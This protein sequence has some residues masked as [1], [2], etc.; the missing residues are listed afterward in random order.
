MRVLILE[1][2]VA[3]AEL[4]CGYLTELGHAPIVARTPA[5]AL[6]ALAT[7]SP[8][9]VMLDP[10]LPGPN[11]VEF[12]R[13]QAARGQRL[14]LVAISSAASEEQARECLRLGALDYARKPVSLTRLAELVSFLELHALNTRL[15]E[16]VR[17][18][19]RRRGARASTVFPVHIVEDTGAAWV[20]LSV[21]LSPFGIRIRSPGRFKE[22]A[23]AKLTFTPPDG[24]PALT[25]L[26]VLARSTDS[27]GDAFLFV[28][29]AVAEFHRLSAIVRKL[30]QPR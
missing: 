10:A 5:A 20:G 4:Y 29:L 21:D 23:L 13:L 6:E 8:E 15:A 3:T 2:D 19:D 17:S 25:V 14:P 16:Q 11:G 30:S 1:E 22:G 28:N 24:L 18:L 9:A 12:L 27:D 7:K 26:S